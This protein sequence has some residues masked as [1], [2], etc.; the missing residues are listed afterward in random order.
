MNLQMEKQEESLRGK[1]GDIWLEIIGKNHDR[2]KAA[3][4]FLEIS[5]EDTWI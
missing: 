4:H 1:G 3:V 5:S 2:K